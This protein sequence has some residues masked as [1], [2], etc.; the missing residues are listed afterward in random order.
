MDS[1]DLTKVV[2]AESTLIGT[3]MNS[4]IMSGVDFTSANLTEAKLTALKSGNVIFFETKLHE[5]DL[6]QAVLF[7]CR[8]TKVSFKVIFIYNLFSTKYII[9]IIIT[10]IITIILFI[11]LFM[12]FIDLR[13]FR[14]SIHWLQF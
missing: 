4:A 12:Y 9:I 5:T 14:D 10:I 1:A 6:S 13:I 3:D 2:L 11:Y 7:S 8:F